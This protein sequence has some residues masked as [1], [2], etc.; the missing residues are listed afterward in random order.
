VY[1]SAV[2]GRNLCRRQSALSGDSSYLQTPIE[3]KS[4]GGAATTADCRAAT[5]MKAW[6]TIDLPQRSGQ[7]RLRHL[8]LPLPA[9]RIGRVQ[10]EWPKSGKKVRFSVKEIPQTNFGLKQWTLHT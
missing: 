6:Y 10:V 9:P 3:A 1:E 7:F 2:S 5:Q 4:D 8:F